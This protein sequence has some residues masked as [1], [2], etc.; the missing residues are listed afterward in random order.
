MTALE[1]TFLKEKS[2]FFQHK[3]EVLEG[4]K[5]NYISSIDIKH[6]KKLFLIANQPM[7]DKLKFDH[8]QCTLDILQKENEFMK[9]TILKLL[10]KINF[11]ESQLG[12]RSSFG[13]KNESYQ[14][15]SKL[16]NSMADENDN[17][18][19][20]EEFDDS[21]MVTSAVLNEEPAITTAFV[22]SVV[23]RTNKNQQTPTISEPTKTIE[24]NTDYV[25]TTKTALNHLESDLHCLNVLKDDENCTSTK[26]NRDQVI[27]ELTGHSFQVQEQIGTVKNTVN[28]FEYVSNPVCALNELCMA[29]NWL[30]PKYEFFKDNDSKTFTYSVELTVLTYIVRGK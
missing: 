24:D 10:N 17:I 11:I 25:L 9:S 4:M 22:N 8:F 13:N 30:L 15:N 16:I 19:W 20:G 2:E 28:D 5:P 12:N 21:H 3:V 1:I 18:C 7:N 6:C 23:H 27:H 29:R 14:M 26:G